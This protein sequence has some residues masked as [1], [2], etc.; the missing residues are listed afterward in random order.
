[1]RAAAAAS[2]LLA[3]AL[4]G[5]IVGPK[6]HKPR[7]AT[8]PAWG[9]LEGRSDLA[10]LSRTTSDE[11]DLSRWWSAFN[12][13]EL[14]RL[15]ARALAGNLNLKV[16]G[17]RIRQ[18]RQQE[19]VA[20]AAGLPTLEAKP[21]AF[22]VQISRNAIPPSISQRIRVAPGV[23]EFLLNFDASWE[24]DLF[25]GV[26]R[27]V[28]AARAQ[29]EAAVW[30]R[31]D[32][33]VSLTAEVATDYLAYRGDQ[34]RAV[35]VQ[36]EI[37]R[38][39]ENMNILAEQAR[40]GLVP[41]VNV[42]Q[43]R[44]QYEN[45]RALLPMIQADERVQVHALSVL[46]GL[47]PQALSAELAA[48]APL[49]GPP[50]V[51]PAGLPA[52]LLRRRPDIRASE[53]QLAAA[54]AEI[55]VAIA[56]LY[57]TLTLDPSAGLV[58]TTLDRLFEVNSGQYILNGSVTAPLYEGG[59]LR[60]NVRS[61]REERAQA[62]LQ[63]ENVLLTS[64]RDVEDAL[65]RYAAE[66]RRETALASSAAA[67]RRAAD[68]AMAQFQGGQVTYINVLVAEQSALQAQ[69]QLAQSDV[70]LDQDLAS[71]FKA[72]GGGWDPSDPADHVER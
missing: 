8:P 60:A 54:N 72:L 36:G 28:E 22:H 20:A 12:D 2:V 13:P 63:Y 17:S 7:L 69:D 55:G 71:L 53:R 45:S 15:V 18:A 61:A 35:I 64:M 42:V 38:Q 49:P 58:S 27:S 25:G 34:Q 32:S 19:I 9:G 59:K 62:L 24:V 5:C 50:P 33:E 52:D 41:T 6:Y 26:R 51:V 70:Q 14:D 65:A 1:M 48:S 56:Q 16:A 44:T 37:D 40:G 3:L 11:A 47:D 10:P 39:L 67:A 31:R 4:S 68:V 23:S 30:N 21:Q 57:P 29:T 46:L 43:Q 66:Q